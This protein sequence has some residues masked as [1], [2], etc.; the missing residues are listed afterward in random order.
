MSLGAWHTLNTPV[1]RS[2]RSSTH[3]PRNMPSHALPV[4]EAPAQRA[5]GVLLRP[6][7]AQRSGFNHA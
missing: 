5:T 1:T 2:Q 3:G 6:I 7:L 4:P